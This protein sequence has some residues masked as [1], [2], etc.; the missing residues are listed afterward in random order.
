VS[1]T[2]EE[3]TAQ[4]A[5]QHLGGLAELLVDVVGDGASVNFM[6]PFGHDDALRFWRSVLDRVE[7]GEIRL[8][9]AFRDGALDGTVQLQLASQ[10]NQPHRADVAK[11]L[12]HTRARRL[13]VA[14]NLMLAL[15]EIARRHGRALLT[16]DTLA[17][18]PAERLY[19]SLGY[20]VVGQIPGYALLP[21][22][23]EPLP[24]SIIYKQL[25]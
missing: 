7:A 18:T 10:P 24:T 19:R 22:G 4:Q 2:I 25:A 17:G 23:G 14:R 13:A 9:A 21:G 20:T 15:E 12:V 1:H 16:L 3:L 11:L 8:L 5:R 6:L